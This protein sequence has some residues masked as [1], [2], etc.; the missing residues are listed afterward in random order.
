MPRKIMLTALV[1][2]PLAARAQGVPARPQAART[3]A[4]MA[5]YDG[6]RVDVAA[7]QERLHGDGAILDPA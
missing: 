1:A 6:V 4:A 2:T 5:D 7:L 3:A